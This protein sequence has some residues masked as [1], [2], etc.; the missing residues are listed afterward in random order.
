MNKKTSYHICIACFFTLFLRKNFAQNRKVL[1]RIAQKNE[2]GAVKSSFCTVLC[3]VDGTFQYIHILIYAY[4][5]GRPNNTT[6]IV[7]NMSILRRIE[8]FSA[9][10]SFLGILK[11][12]LPSFH[13]AMNK[14]HVLGHFQS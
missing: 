14:Y 2:R 12:L 1:R 13:C 4:T 11:A 6:S 9:D 10:F 7:L 5:F 3:P 8:K